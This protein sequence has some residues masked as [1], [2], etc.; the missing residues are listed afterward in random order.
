MPSRPSM[1]RAFFMPQWSWP[2]NGLIVS[3]DPVALDYTGWQ[4][5]RTKTS[6][7]GPQPLR[8]VSSASR[9]HRSYAA[10]PNIGSETN[11]PNPSKRW[12]S[13]HGPAGHFSRP[14]PCPAWQPAPPR[15][16]PRQAP[17]NDAQFTIEARFYEKLPYKK[18]KCKLCPANVSSMTMSAVT[19]AS[20]KTAA[21][22]TTR[23]CYSRRLFRPRRPIEKKPLFHFAP[24]TMAVSIATPVATSTARCARTG[25]SRSPAPNRSRATYLPPKSVPA[26]AQRN[27]CYPSPYTYSEPVVFSEYVMD[28]AEAAAAFRREERWSISGGYI[29]RSR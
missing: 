3:R 27:N 8:R 24:G 25:R 21:A 5:H 12:R 13:N 19:A 9:L 1:K 28:T 23:W 20:A 2:F 18:I 15:T 4:I 29:Q 11:D 10:T 6:R 17:A 14:L 26:L 22:L 16:R 7:K